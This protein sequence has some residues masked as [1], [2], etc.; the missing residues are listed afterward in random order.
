MNKLPLL[1]LTAIF[2]HSTTFADNQLRLVGQFGKKAV[3]LINGNQQVLSTNHTSPE[4]VKL[5]SVKPEYIVVVDNG[6]KKNVYY[7]TQISTNYVNPSVKEVNI[8]ENNNGSYITNG[9]INNQPVS[10]LID[11]GATTIAMSEVTA[12]KLG[13]DFKHAG[14]PIQTATASDITSSFAVKLKSVQVGSIHLQDIDA[15]VMKKGFP[16]EILLGMSFL[17][18]VEL[19]RKNNQ[20]TLRLKRY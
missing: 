18:L 20:M 13:I 10:F 5:V 6:Q 9:Y 17:R 7:S 3:I 15:V 16:G 1:F 4:G 12:N 8:R 14:T 19:Q 2:C 11:T